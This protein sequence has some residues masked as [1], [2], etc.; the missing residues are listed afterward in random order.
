MRKAVERSRHLNLGKDSCS[1]RCPVPRRKPRSDSGARPT[2][3]KSNRPFAGC[4]DQLVGQLRSPSRWSVQYRV[5]FCSRS[6][7]AWAGRPLEWSALKRV[8]DSYRSGAGC[9]L[10]AAGIGG[11][12]GATDGRT[13]HGSLLD[14]APRATRRHMNLL[15]GEPVLGVWI[16]P[17]VCDPGSHWTLTRKAEPRT[18]RP[19]VLTTRLMTVTGQANVKGGP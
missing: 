1:P 5:R 4:P 7:L 3:P 6:G 13:G 14:C 15:G 16:L 11:Q 8:D 19:V 17:N 12:L 9:R 2:P 18:L 10:L